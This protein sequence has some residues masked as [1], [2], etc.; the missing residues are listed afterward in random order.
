MTPA[1]AGRRVSRIGRESGSVAKVVH[2]MTTLPNFLPT[3]S[4]PERSITPLIV[5]A[6][7]LGTLFALRSINPPSAH[8]GACCIVRRADTRYGSV[9]H[10]R[11]TDHR[12]LYE[13][14]LPGVPHRSRYSG[15]RWARRAAPLLGSTGPARLADPAIPGPRENG[16]RLCDRIG[17]R[18]G[19]V[20]RAGVSGRHDADMVWRETQ[21]PRAGEDCVVS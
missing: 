10:W 5:V 19:V 1:G 2:R 17:H 12:D 16:A 7:L 4:M 20:R 11:R 13:S 9:G 14:R 18:T 6:L 15:G 8:A 3:G 21:R